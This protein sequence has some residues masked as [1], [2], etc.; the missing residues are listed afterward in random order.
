M[1]PGIRVSK[2]LFGFC[3]PISALTGQCR[4]PFLGMQRHGSG[5]ASPAPFPNT[6]NFS[7]ATRAFCSN[8][9]W[10]VSTIAGKPTAL[11][12][13]QRWHWPLLGAFGDLRIRYGIKLGL[14]ALLSLYV[15]LLLR[16][17][18][19]NWAVLTALIMMG[20]H[21][22]GSIAVKAI[23]RVVGTIGGA[24][25][26]IWL[27]GDYV[28]TS[29]I[30][31]P[32]FFLVMTFAG[33]K[34]GQFPASQVPY[35]YFLVGLTTL[36]VVT[37]GVTDPA[38]V[39]QTG[40]NRTLE[41]LDG[42][43]SSLIVTT[44]VW[45]R[46]AREEFVESAQTA[47]KTASH[48]VSMHIEAY[49]S[50]T[51]VPAEAD[52]IDQD[53]AAR[54]SVLKNLLQNG[55]RESTV[56][57]AHVSTYNAALVSMTNLFH[58]A[59]DLSRHQVE[60][61]ILSRVQH[62][63]QALAAG[64]SEE[65]D[66]L[67]GQHR[68]GEKLRPSRLNEAFAAFE[69]KVN[70][71]RSQEVFVAAPPATTRAF[72][73]GFA[74]LR[75]LRD[76][77]N[78]LRSLSEGLPRLGQPLPEPKPHW[79][80]VPTIDWFWVKAGIKGGISAVI[81]I[82]LLKWINP[83]G[84]ASIPLM[85]W[86][87]SLFGRPFLRAGGTG[88][89]RSFQNAFLAALVLS[90]CAALLILT[91]PFMADYLV[92]NLALFFILFWLGFI[93]VRTAGVTFPIQVANLSMSTF[94][95]LNP[96]VPVASQTIIDS[97]L[98]LIIGMGIATLVGRLIWPVLPQKLLRDDL[99]AILSQIKALLGG[100]ANREKI[101]TQLA[102]LPVEA[103]QAA[104]QIRMSG[105]A[106][107]EKARLRA[108]VRALQALVTR[109]TELVYRRHLLPEIMEPVLRPQ[110][111]RLEIEF[112]QMLDALIECF[113][114]GD[115]RREFPNLRA[116]LAD[117]DQATENIAANRL[118]LGHGLEAPV[119]ML[120]LVDRY[121][122]TGEALEECGRLARTLKLHRYWGDYAL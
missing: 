14:A 10:L 19:P 52:Q 27:V 28:S 15:A 94:V 117:I 99:I 114:R 59:L 93:N 102:I 100:A 55:A 39:W 1:R 8:R 89:M 33:Y 9:N 34:F 43:I 73:A 22:V 87:L 116:P 13:A 40:L 29:E 65:F 120:D 92:M 54:L 96:Q 77:L 104:R 25:M 69:K 82:V 66:I 113:R 37:Y 46:Y 32:A 107:D 51:N 81:A 91:T 70:E 76:E 74:A 48:L 101:Q 121:H 86:T 122:A 98:G 119:G 20:S 106:E 68:P 58:A 97:F 31:L 24:L 2:R 80:F 75:S 45:P 36:S 7:F 60:P 44:L 41:I 6:G 12:V 47:L 23:M 53:F 109:T 38:D 84:P 50:R 16:L 72:Y 115:C 105:C 67:T 90:G 62:E 18:H 78:N 30:F 21:Y 5:G 79:N 26:G 103:L 42:A 63:I 56:F 88:D 112:K 3:N 61:S 111:E 110:F 57:S 108:L 83:P 17:E 11:P 85:A 64:V 49:T 4:S 118:L 35:A 71:M 95:G